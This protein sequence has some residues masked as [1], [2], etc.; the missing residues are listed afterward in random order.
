[1]TGHFRGH[2]RGHLQGMFHLERC[3]G[4]THK[5]HREKVLN[6]MNFWIFQGVFGVFSGVFRYF[7]GVSGF[8]RV[9]SGCFRVF[10]GILREFQ[11]FSGCFSPCPFRV[12]PLDPFNPWDL[13][14]PQSLFSVLG[15]KIEHKTLSSQ[16]FR[17][18]PGY[19][20]RGSPCRTSS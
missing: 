1:M 4:H 10:S 6:V 7:P 2:F 11:D 8:F 15:P 12:C 18:P 13:S 14:G 16:P 17:A 20:W 5:G 9:F 19:P 3:K